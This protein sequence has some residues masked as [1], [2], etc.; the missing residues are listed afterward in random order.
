[1]NNG[2]M[3]NVHRFYIRQSRLKCS[4]Y[5]TQTLCIVDKLD[6]VRHK[7]SMHFRNKNSEYLIAKVN[8]FETKHKNNR[9]L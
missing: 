4:G 8:E 1:M 9:D 7:D 6:N 2:L 5:R 3:K